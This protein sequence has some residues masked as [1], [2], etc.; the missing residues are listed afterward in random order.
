MRRAGRE[1]KDTV[2]NILSKS[3]INDPHVNWLLEKSKCKNKL[4]IMMEYVFGE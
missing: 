4:R 1:D 3:F 2:V